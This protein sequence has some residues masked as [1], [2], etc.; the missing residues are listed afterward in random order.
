MLV[1]GHKFN[2]IDQGHLYADRIVYNPSSLDAESVFR[3]TTKAAA[4][5]Q[6][7]KD[8]SDIGI[9]TSPDPNMN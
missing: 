2:I 7:V 9:K 5:S 3:S 1:N 4:A 8:S 6:A